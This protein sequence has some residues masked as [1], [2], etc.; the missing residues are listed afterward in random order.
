M[1]QNISSKILRYRVVLLIIVIL[2][3][4]FMIFNATKVEMSYEYAP[5]LPK[6]DS[7]S[8]EHREFV[9]LFG[10]EGN[11]ITIG[12]V[13]PDFF[14]LEHFNN[15]R[16]YCEELS[17]IDGVDN[18]ISIPNTVHLV[19]NTEEKKFD[20]LK[21][22]KEDITS[23]AAL[24]SMASIFHT[25]PLYRGYLYNDS[26]ETYLVA[27]TMNKDRM[28]TKE[29]EKLVKNIQK[30]SAQFEKASG[31]YLHYSGLPYI[32]VVNSIMIKKEIYLF[33]GL[34]LLICIAILFFFFRSFKAMLF[35]ALVVLAGVFS[36]LGTMSLFGYHI[37]ILT[38]MIP[39]L[40]DCHRYSKQYIHVEQVSQRI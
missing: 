28:K 3:T 39:P 29:R 13:D 2:Y 27:L 10:E 30:V 24:D 37:T 11:L 18:M 34:A 8:I 21:I 31:H 16:D 20:L 1:W 26:T 14:T 23:Q 15:W 25:L 38:G 40:F 12:V 5:L 4:I 36:A 32:R 19:K 33:S 22:F 9:D 7:A 6:S 17:N 35:P